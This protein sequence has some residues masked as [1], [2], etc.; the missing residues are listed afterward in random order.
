MF[1]VEIKS[2]LWRD[3]L[4]NSSVFCYTVIKF[5]PT[6]SELLVNILKLKKLKNLLQFIQNG[7]F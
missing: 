7:L 3:S 6:V 2:F 5:S 4:S 1:F